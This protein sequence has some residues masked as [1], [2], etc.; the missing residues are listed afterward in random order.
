MSATVNARL[1][2]RFDVV[3]L[4]GGRAPSWGESIW[5]DASALGPAVGRSAWETRDQG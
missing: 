3:E 5:F 2:R 1:G 4:R